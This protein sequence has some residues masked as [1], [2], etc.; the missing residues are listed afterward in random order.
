M[1]SSL[2]LSFLIRKTEIIIFR[3]LDWAVDCQ[4]SILAPPPLSCVV[5]ALD[6]SGLKVVI[7]NS[8]VTSEELPQR[9]V[10]GLEE[11]IS[12]KHSTVSDT[13]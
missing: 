9:D 5:R 1:A 6:S 11:L 13:Q 8:V 4:V 12:A 7:G 10:G 3:S 2:S